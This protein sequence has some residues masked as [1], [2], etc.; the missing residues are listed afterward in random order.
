MSWTLG[1]REEYNTRIDVRVKEW[2]GK[3][4][5]HIRHFDFNKDNDRWFPTGKGV[6]LNLN[7]WDKFVDEFQTIDLEV[8]RLRCK[9]EQTEAVPPKRVKRDL[10]S[11]LDKENEQVPPKKSKKDLREDNER[12]GDSIS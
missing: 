12:K 4:Q 3:I 10:Q 6:A 1:K 8:R 9:N 11:T 5:I 7:E 2:K